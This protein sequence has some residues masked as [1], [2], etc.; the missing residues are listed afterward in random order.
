MCVCVDVCMYGCVQ[1]C[2]CMCCVNVVVCMCGC[3]VECVDA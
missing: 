1:L 3:V 2:G